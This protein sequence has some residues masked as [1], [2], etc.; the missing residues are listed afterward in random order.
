MSL[1]ILI[2]LAVRK[3]SCPSKTVQWVKMPAIKSESL[4]SVF[5]TFM[6]EGEGQLLQVVTPC[7]N[8]CKQM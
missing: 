6:M 7:V 8:S 5:R 3:Y 4:S 2:I 1:V